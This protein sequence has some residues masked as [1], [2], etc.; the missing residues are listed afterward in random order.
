MMP[1]APGLLI[2]DFVPESAASPGDWSS[3]TFDQV[4]DMS[5]GNF[6]SAA[7][8][9]DALFAS[10]PFWKFEYY[11]DLIRAAFD[12]PHSVDPGTQWVYRTPDTFILT[13]ALHNYL[14]EVEGPEA[15]VFQFVVDEVY[16][17][18]KIN[19][20]GHTVLR[21]RDNNWQGQ[22]MG[23]FGQ[24]LIPDDVAKIST[25]LNS[26]GVIDG[27]QILHR[28]I[29]DAALQR[30]PADRGVDIDTA[31]K[32]NNAFWAQRYGVAEGFDCEFWVPQMM[33]FS[34]VVVALFPNGATYYYASDNREFTWE[35]ALREADKVAPLCGAE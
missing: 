31:R 1:G 33:G 6:R 15:D 35:T 13:R 5:S 34:G 14:Q 24:W 8:E 26:G 19:P 30:D 21:T 11:A 32:Y 16:R 28:G 27:K 23:G 2:R 12:R 4:L 9:D 18:L 10:D 25:L 22:A 17:P 29:L 20:G 7:F 3:V